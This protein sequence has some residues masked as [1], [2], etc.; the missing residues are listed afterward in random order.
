MKL[1]MSFLVLAMALQAHAVNPPPPAHSDHTVY[2]RITSEPKGVTIYVIP[3]EGGPPELLGVT[4]YTLVSELTWGRRMIGRQWE[5]LNVW[6]PG[7][8]CTTRYEATNKTH[9]LTARF[10]AAKA[11]YQPIRVQRDILSIAKKGFDAERYKDRP[12]EK[13]IE[14]SLEERPPEETPVAEQPVAPATVVLATGSGPD[15]STVGRVTVESTQPD[16]DIMI[17]G[18]L[19]A[20]TP[21]TLVMWTGS[22]DLSVE[23]NGETLLNQRLTVG[24]EPLQVRASD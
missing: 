17:D 21:A 2:T 13:H 16:A 5:D 10:L 9:T 11:G 14:L 24:T 15:R 6:S 8:T 19:V 3:E 20:T 12:S 22:Y 23:Q 7:S 18:K 1:K 4:P